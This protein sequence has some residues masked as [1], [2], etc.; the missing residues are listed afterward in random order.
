MH[1]FVNKH[2]SL[3]TIVQFIEPFAVYFY[4]VGHGQTC[5][6][7]KYLAEAPNTG[8]RTGLRIET[9]DAIYPVFVD[10]LKF[11]LMYEHID[12]FFD[13]R[14]NYILH[15]NTYGNSNNKQ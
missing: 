13:I 5:Y 14:G 10:V 7:M 8:N 4:D 1:E 3:L 11:Y 9:A 12:A 6:F 15:R 2:F